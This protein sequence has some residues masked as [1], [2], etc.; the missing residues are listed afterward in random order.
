[1][2]SASGS[3]ADIVRSS[4]RSDA[5]QQASQT[6]LQQNT[7]TDQT[8]EDYMI[9]AF[10]SDILQKTLFPD[11]DDPSSMPALDGNGSW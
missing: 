11:P 6:E 9:E 5:D 7:V 10:K 8:V 3:L 1:M 4:L 2:E